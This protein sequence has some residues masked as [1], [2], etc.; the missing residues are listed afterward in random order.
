MCL[1]YG[2]SNDIP[3][4]HITQIQQ[5]KEGLV[6]T[7]CAGDGWIGGRIGQLT[8]SS[9]VGVFIEANMG[10]AMSSSSV[11]FQCTRDLIVFFLPVNG[12]AI[13]NNVT[14]SILALFDNW[15]TSASL[16]V[17]NLV[18]AS[19]DLVVRSVAN[20]SMAGVVLVQSVIKLDEGLVSKPHTSSDWLAAKVP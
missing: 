5:S 1:E 16:R 6:M 20:N 10:V 14:I 17:Q 13:E 3:T 11:A 18:P 12:H 4:P 9:L 8:R 7:V 19:Y 15:S 2:M